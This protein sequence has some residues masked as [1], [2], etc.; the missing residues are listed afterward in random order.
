[1][2][3]GLRCSNRGQ[4]YISWPQTGATTSTIDDRSAPQVDEV[5]TQVVSFS[6]QRT[7]ESFYDFTRSNFRPGDCEETLEVTG[8]LR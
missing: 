2:C 6:F 7:A 3:T 4:V 5:E 8:V 1:M